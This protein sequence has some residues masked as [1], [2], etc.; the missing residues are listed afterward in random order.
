MNRAERRRRR[1][2]TRRVYQGSS[3]VAELRPT[4][5]DPDHVCLRLGIGP[6]G[7]APVAELALCSTGLDVL[8]S[9]LR[10]AVAEAQLHGFAVIEDGA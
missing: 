8:F 2:P 9:D 3:I 1:L 6:E 7:S 10:L 5:E 4:P